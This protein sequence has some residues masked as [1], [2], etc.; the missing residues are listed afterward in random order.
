MGALD[1]LKKFYFSVEDKYYAFC[2]W[3]EK[4]G[5]KILVVVLLHQGVKM[6]NLAVFQ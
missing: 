1:G 6:G 2:D 4:K 5:V 3:L